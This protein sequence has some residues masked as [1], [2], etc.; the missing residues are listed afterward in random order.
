MDEIVVAIGAS[1]DERI[2][3]WFQNYIQSKY[4]VLLK[5]LD[6]QKSIDLSMKQASEGKLRRIA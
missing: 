5:D 3:D 1:K 6:L 2:R 4:V